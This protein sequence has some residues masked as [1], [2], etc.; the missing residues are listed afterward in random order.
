[1]KKTNISSARL[2][3]RIR[4]HPYIAGTITIGLVLVAVV[5]VRSNDQTVPASTTEQPRAVSTIAVANY[6]MH[7]GAI[8]TASANSFVLRSEIGGRVQDVT[9]QSTV[10]KGAVIAELEN[11]GQYAALLQAQGAYEAA[12]AGTDSSATQHAAAETGAI[13]TWQNVTASAAQ[14]VRTTLDAHFTRPSDA[15]PGFRLESFGT[16]PKL[17]DMRVTIENTLAIWESR[18]LNISETAIIPALTELEQ[19]LILIESLANDIAGLLPRQNINE[20]FSEADRTAYVTALS[21]A[22]T[23]LTTL[24]RSVDEAQTLLMQTAGSTT[25]SANAQVKQALGALRAAESAYEKTRIKAPFNGTITS[26]NVSAGDII[27]AGA[28]IAIIVPDESADAG[29]AFDLPLSS[30]KFTPTGA[31]VFTINNDVL[32]AHSVETGL[33]TA[34][35][36]TV[37]GLIGNEHIVKDVRGLKNGEE[38]IS[39]DEHIEN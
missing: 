9:T 21:G 20:H 13:R 23:S 11:S 26:Q 17:N 10:T 19:D 7:G 22:Q 27:T 29:M 6:G 12:L 24:R 4:K 14:I 30:V 37:T 18:A 32:V 25:D 28:D 15:V 33:V 2:A 35:S 38:V 39:A 34:D 5:L 8:L 1:M 16:A 36:I 3:T 31:T